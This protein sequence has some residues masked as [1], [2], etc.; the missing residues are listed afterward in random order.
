M[1]SRKKRFRINVEILI[2]FAIAAC[3]VFLMNF[4]DSKLNEVILSDQEALLINHDPNNPIHEELAKEILEF[5][6]DACKMIEAFTEDFDPMFRIQFKEDDILDDTRITDYPD[7]IEVFANNKEGHT[8]LVIGDYEED[9]YFQWTEVSSG[10]SYLVII[11]MSRPVVK[12]LWV[13]SS[14]CYLI[15]FLVGTLIVMMNLRSHNEKIRQYQLI[16]GGLSD[17]IIR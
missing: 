2:S 1:Y 13:F 14:I 11:Y 4:A 7:L 5:R 12:N 9:V 6:P 17:K 16:S 8:N 3:V 10:E 15:L